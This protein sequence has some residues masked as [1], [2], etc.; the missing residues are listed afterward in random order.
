MKIYELKDGMPVRQIQKAYKVNVF[1]REIEDIIYDTKIITDG[2]IESKS[3]QDEKYDDFSRIDVLR[4]TNLYLKN[5]TYAIV[6][7]IGREAFYNGKVGGIVDC[8]KNITLYLRNLNDKE[9]LKTA[10]QVIKQ[11]RQANSEY[12]DFSMNSLLREDNNDFIFDVLDENVYSAKKLINEKIKYKVSDLYLISAKGKEK[13]NYFLCTYNPLYN[14]YIEVLT[15]RIIEPDNDVE[16]YYLPLILNEL[17][18]KTNLHKKINYYELIYLYNELGKM[19]ITNLE[20][21]CNLVDSG[22]KVMAKNKA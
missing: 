9:A 8:I 22:K 13:I 7:T 20:D 1:E 4:T 15:N 6:L 3:V 16:K 2:L 10:K 12:K 11:I 21:K 17:N 18:I 5:Y 19:S 14:C